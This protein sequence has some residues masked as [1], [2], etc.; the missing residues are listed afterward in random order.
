MDKV[1][2]RNGFVSNSSS[3]SFVVCFPHK[4]ADLVDMQRMLFDNEP[5]YRNPY[6]F[7]PD[8]IGVFAASDVAARVF[9]DI[10]KQKPL[11]LSQ[12][13]EKLDIHYDSNVKVDDMERPEYPDYPDVLYGMEM[14][15]RER[16]PLYKKY[17]K[18]TREY[19]KKSKEW[20]EKMAASFIANAKGGGEFYTFE[21]ED[22]NGPMETA[23]EHGDLFRRLP[24]IRVSNH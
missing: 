7:G 19:D 18:E 2:T 23:M 24:Y 10:K 5:G 3:S 11:T 4:P 13:A 17:M 6:V 15:E 21:Y 16:H 8:D 14:K 20:R 1:K 12:I 9:E 22:H